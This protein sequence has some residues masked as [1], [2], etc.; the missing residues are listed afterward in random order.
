MSTA[1]AATEGWA[2]VAFEI[3]DA[4]AESNERRLRESITRALP[5]DVNSAE[6]ARKTRREF[7]PNAEG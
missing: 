5:A 6:H 4:A 3:G 2:E 1:G 7:R